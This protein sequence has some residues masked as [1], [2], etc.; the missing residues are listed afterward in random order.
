M[1]GLQAPH[2]FTLTAPIIVLSFNATLA[3]SLLLAN[4]TRAHTR[5]HALG[6]LREPRIRGQHD[7]LG[8]KYWRG[9]S[10]R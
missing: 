2:D 8:L 6:E 5:I 9:G 7:R 10:M 3:L 4:H 1:T